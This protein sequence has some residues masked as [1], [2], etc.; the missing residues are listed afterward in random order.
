MGLVRAALTML[1]GVLIACG[2]GSM[3]PTGSSGDGGEELALATVVPVGTTCGSGASAVYFIWGLS[4]SVR[5][6]GVRPLE[7]VVP[8]GQTLR[9]TLDFEGCGGGTGEV[10]TSTHTEVGDLTPDER[11]SA[12]THFTARAPGQ[13]HPF[14]RVGRHGGVGPINLV[15]R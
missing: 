7:A 9:L 6:P 8:V 4:N 2:D 12:V 10:W 15:K 3:S 14:W 11:F 5:D 13:D 1:T